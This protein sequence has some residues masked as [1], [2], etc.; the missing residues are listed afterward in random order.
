LIRFGVKRAFYKISRIKLIIPYA[1]A[2][3][4]TAFFGSEGSERLQLQM[5][6]NQIAIDYPTGSPLPTALKRTIAQFPD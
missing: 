6:L 4:G 2:D 3:K 5:L 1:I